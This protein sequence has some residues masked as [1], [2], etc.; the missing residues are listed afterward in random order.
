MCPHCMQL[1]KAGFEPF[2]RRD[3]TG[4][5]HFENAMPWTYA[6]RGRFRQCH[7]PVF[8][9]ERRTFD[10]RLPRYFG[11]P[12]GRKMDRSIIKSSNVSAA[13]RWL[14]CNPLFAHVMRVEDAWAYR[15][16]VKL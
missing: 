15:R 13:R 1:E 10:R 14:P 12:C 9:R 16:G 3:H 4:R 2:G 11:S 6:G 8:A 5:V 7:W